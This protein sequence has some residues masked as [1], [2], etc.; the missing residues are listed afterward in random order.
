[1]FGIKKRRKPKKVDD[2]RTYASWGELKSSI[3]S[4]GIDETLSLIGSTSFQTNDLLRGILLSFTRSSIEVTYALLESIDPKRLPEYKSYYNQVFQA[5][6]NHGGIELDN[7]YKIYPGEINED[8]ILEDFHENRY[9]L[10]LSFEKALSLWPR[11]T[12][13]I[14]NDQDYAAKQMIIQNKSWTQRNDF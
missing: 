10:D 14:F 7:F 13:A 6:I 2:G 12:V 1:M 4:D 11:F 9:H 5:A 8:L 3:D